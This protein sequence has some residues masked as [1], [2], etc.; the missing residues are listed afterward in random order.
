MQCAPASAV[1]PAKPTVGA[2]QS[3]FGIDFYGAPDPFQMARDGVRFE[4][5]YLSGV[6]GKDWTAGQLAEAHA[7][8]LQ[9]AVVFERGAADALGGCEAGL[10]DARAALA[11]ANELGVPSNVGIPLAVDFDASSGEIASYFHCAHEVLGSRAG[12]YGG[13]FQVAAMNADGYT[14]CKNDYQTV[15]WSQGNRGCAGIYQS[16]INNSLVGDGN[17][18]FDHADPNSADLW[19]SAKKP[20]PQHYN[21]YDFRMRTFHVKVKHG[22]KVVSRTIKAKERSAVRKWDKNGCRNPVKRSICRTMRTHM[23]LL[24]GRAQRVYK[25]QTKAQRNKYH[26]PGRIQGLA[27]RLNKPGIV[28]RW[29]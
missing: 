5:S 27:H 3:I 14:F 15:A 28:K 21:R 12:I 11:E 23:K 7:A 4:D 24:L 22:K 13:Y 17:I 8:H 1:K 20:D 19:P 9:T 6:P 18:D 29:I 2:A 25:G 10:T 26:T 16:S